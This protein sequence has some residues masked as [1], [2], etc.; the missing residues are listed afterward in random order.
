MVK[1][2]VN[3]DDIKDIE[4]RIDILEN[5]VIRNSRWI[6]IFQWLLIFSIIMTL[7]SFI[8]ILTISY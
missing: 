1:L 3:N 4:E 5:A 8:L 2:K 6:N 7:I